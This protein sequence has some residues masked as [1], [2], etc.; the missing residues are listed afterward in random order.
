M[1]CFIAIVIVSAL[2]GGIGY[3]IGER[4]M[5]GVKIDLDNTRNELEKVKARVAKKAN[6]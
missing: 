4:G 1:E 6:A 5:A 3:Y 2:I